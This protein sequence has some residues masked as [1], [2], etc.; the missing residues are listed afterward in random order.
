MELRKLG[1]GD[2]FLSGDYAYSREEDALAR[3]LEASH[4]GAP[5]PPPIARE[6]PGEERSSVGAA[7]GSRR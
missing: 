2:S 6:R 4:E 1:D 7:A 3:D 5:P